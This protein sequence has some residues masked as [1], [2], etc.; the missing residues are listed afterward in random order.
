MFSLRFSVIIYFILYITLSIFVGCSLSNLIR[1]FSNKLSDYKDVLSFIICAKNIDEPSPDCYFNKCKDCPGIE[2]LVTYLTMV[3]EEND[4]Q[5]ISYSQWLQTPV[6]TL[7]NLVEDVSDFIP[8][9]CSKV[10][11]LLP[12]AFISQQQSLNFKKTLKSSLPENEFIIN[13][14]FAENYAFI[15]QNAPPGFHWNNDQATVFV[16]FVYYKLNNELK[17]KGF[18]IIS[19]NLDHDTVAV[20]IYQKLI[21]DYLNANFTVS[22][23]HYF[24]DGVPQQSKNF[25]NILNIYFHFQDFGIVADWNFFPTA[26]GKG[27]M[28]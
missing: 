27:V 14:D 24:S 6:T 22:K 12:H 11:A 28:D 17:S 8:Y 3:F 1:N 21:V 26:H 23:I 4:M 13:L 16:G 10:S 20:Y 18:I 19:D 15:A 7:K 9:F 5:E 25:K 2:K